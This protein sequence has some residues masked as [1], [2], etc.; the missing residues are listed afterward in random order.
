MM[1]STGRPGAY[2]HIVPC[3]KS[4]TAWGS[5]IRTSK[6]QLCGLYS[7]LQRLSSVTPDDV[8]DIH[9]IYGWREPKWHSI[10]DKIENSSISS[11][12]ALSSI[13]NDP[14]TADRLYQLRTDGH[15]LSHSN[16]AW[17]HPDANP[18]CHVWRPSLP[19]PQQRLHQPNTPTGTSSTT[20]SATVTDGII[21]AS[22]ELYKWRKGGTV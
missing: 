5:P 10:H 16:G 4:V 22:D 21:A 3:T 7:Q 20:S 11:V 6:S 13:A 1:I 14:S 15:I 18:N 19:T 2:S 8:M 9:K 12:I 17:A